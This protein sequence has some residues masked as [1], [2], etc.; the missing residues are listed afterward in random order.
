[1]AGELVRYELA[2]GGSVLVEVA[3]D[4]YGYEQCAR[5]ADG[6]VNAGRTLEAAFAHVVPCARAILRAL[7]EL[8]AAEVNV[9]FGIKLSGEAGV[10][11]A[12]SSAEGHFNVRMAFNREETTQ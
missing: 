8:E 12:R 3:G 5:E 7:G 2:E 10:L 11:I 4:A 9:E 6:L 1:V